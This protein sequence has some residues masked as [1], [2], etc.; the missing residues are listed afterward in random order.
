MKAED[1]INRIKTL[2]EDDS[3]LSG[4]IQ[5][6]YLG[7]RQNIPKNNTPFI[8]IEPINETEEDIIYQR[9]QLRTTFLISAYIMDYDKDR[10]I[11][12][13]ST[14]KGIMDVKNDIKKALSADPTLNSNCIKFYFPNVLYDISDYPMRG[15]QIEMEVMFR[16]DFTTRA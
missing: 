6:V 11:V 2:L 4:Y 9:Q 8:I 3:T 12:G 7:V 13:D 10:Q 16:Q 15:V 14:N 1:C 5:K